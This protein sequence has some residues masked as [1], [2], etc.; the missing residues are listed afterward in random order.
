M[1]DGVIAIGFL[2]NDFDDDIAEYVHQN[3]VNI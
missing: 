2:G 3:D 1:C